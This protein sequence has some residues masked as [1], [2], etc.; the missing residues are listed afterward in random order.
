[1]KRLA[2][3]LAGVASA[4]AGLNV[5][6]DEGCAAACAV[7]E[8]CGFL[9][10][11]LGY[12]PAPIRAVDDCERRCRQSPRDDPAVATLLECLGGTWTPPDGVEVVA[13]CD[14]LTGTSAYVDGLTCAT[15]ATCLE[16]GLP[17][18]AL[19]GEVT[20]QVVLIS[21]ADY[22]TL[23]PETPIAQLYAD[24]LGEVA[25]CSAAL[26]GKNE[27]A[28]TNAADDAAE[29][30][31]NDALCRAG[32]YKDIQVC[33]ELGATS[34]E[35]LVAEQS[36]RPASQL[37]YDANESAACDESSVTFDN[38][39]YALRPG[40]IQTYA[41]VRGALPAAELAQLPGV[42][43][44]TD[45]DGTDGTDTDAAPVDYCLQFVGMNVTV[46]GG[47]NIAL[48]PIGPIAEV[49]ALGL[50]PHTCSP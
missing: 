39:T 49:A 30:P 50:T 45:T 23:I 48:V 5:G 43:E 46:R 37:L 31:C 11:N 17:G 18:A 41:R 21:F 9:P 4:C 40:P 22:A 3:L 44:D 29:L 27:C 13:W 12:D 28:V 32:M 10:S 38:L 16:R 24:A 33:D 1:M 15:A 8:G 2:L 47:E 25:S 14:D 36:K 42:F 6:S 34:I 19:Q 26:C 35:V 7:A 20:L